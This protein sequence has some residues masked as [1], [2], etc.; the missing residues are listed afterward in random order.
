MDK[1]IIKDVGELKMYL[2]L[3]ND[4]VKIYCCGTD[5]MQM[6]M[7]D[8]GVCFDS[9]EYDRELDDEES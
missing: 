1:I 5:N 8:N 9:E 6:F 7:V 4:D 2:S 3:V